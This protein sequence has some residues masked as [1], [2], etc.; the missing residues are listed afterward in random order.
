M[1]PALTFNAHPSSS[2]TPRTTGDDM[3]TDHDDFGGLARDLPQLLQRRHVLKMLA[4]STLLALAACGSDTKT[5]TTSAAAGNTTG[6]TAATNGSATTNA[7]A[8]G[9]STASAATASAATCT[10]INEETAGPFPGDGSNG[11]DALTASGIV[12]S[13]ITSSFGSST[14]V[15]TGVPTTVTL[16]I[17]DTANGCTALANAAVYIWHCDQAGQYS[18]YS[19]GVTNENYLR[20]VQ[21]TDA[22][23]RVTFKTIFPAAYSG[24]WPHM[25]F[26][27]YSS[28]DDATGGGTPIA[29]SQ[30]AMPKDVCDV[31]FATAGYE[32]SVRNFSQTSL[33]TDM[34]FSD[35]GAAH[36]IPTTTGSVADGYTMELSVPT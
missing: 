23:G 35:D 24:R 21:Q 30:L 8:A 12:R 17:Q 10:P 2:Y 32:Q 9:A 15:A 28:V 14:T 22:D 16:A 29:T 33:S 5:A 31:V 19:S 13:D 1:N 3:S 7:P 6:A 20:G 18:M 27:V 25:H 26:E 36:Q 4:G 34:V 11:P